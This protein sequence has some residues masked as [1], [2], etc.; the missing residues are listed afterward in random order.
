[1]TPGVAANE[2]PTLLW[3]TRR[4][5]SPCRLA[6]SLT[7][8]ARLAAATGAPMGRPSTEWPHDLEER[9]EVDG[10]GMVDRV[11][12]LVDHDLFKQLALALAR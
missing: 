2:L 3:R 11:R 1:M 4:A 5:G 6:A 9:L 12:H 10:I 7:A 8:R